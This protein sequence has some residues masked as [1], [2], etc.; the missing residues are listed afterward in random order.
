[1]KLKVILSLVL[2]TGIST[3][4][5][6]EEELKPVTLKHLENYQTEALEMKK[7][8]LPMLLTFVA[9][10]CHYCEIVKEEFLKPMLRSGDYGDRVLLRQLDITSGEEIMLVNGKKQYAGDFAEEHKVIVTPTVLFL[11]AEGTE[12]SERLVGVTTVDYYGGFLD[13][14][15]NASLEALGNPIRTVP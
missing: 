14:G 3:A 15:I 4:V 10:Y 8:K 9:D 11:D 12:I 7:N 6:A 5:V 1:M 2:A 13:E